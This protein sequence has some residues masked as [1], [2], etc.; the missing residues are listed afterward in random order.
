M[1]GKPGI[2][3]EADKQEQWVKGSGEGHGEGPALS[4]NCLLIYFYL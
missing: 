1:T 4:S 3:W 2:Q